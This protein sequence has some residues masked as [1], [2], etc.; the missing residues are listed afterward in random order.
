M[1]GGRGSNRTTLRSGQD[2]RQNP[3][4]TEQIETT[5]KKPLKTILTFGF[6]ASLWY[7]ALTQAADKPNIVVIWGDDIGVHNFRANNP[8]VAGYPISF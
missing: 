7:P 6:A 5:T 3:P 8:G 2:Q 4:A 1:T